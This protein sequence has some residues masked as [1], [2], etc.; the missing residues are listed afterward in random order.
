MVTEKELRIGNWIIGASRGL[1]VMVT[2][3]MIAQ[4]EDGVL[5]VQPIPLNENVLKAC[6]FIYK[7]P[8][9]ESPTGDPFYFSLRNGFVAECF[10]YSNFKGVKYLHE[11]QNL[12]YSLYNAE[13]DVDSTCI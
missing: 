2:G 11:L 1:P 7:S 13:L 4:L 5:G 6:G 12:Y 3:R 9:Y 10:K 8:S